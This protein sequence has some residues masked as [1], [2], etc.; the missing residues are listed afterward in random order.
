MTQ[1]IFR[2][3][4]PKSMILNEIRNVVNSGNDPGEFPKTFSRYHPDHDMCQHMHLISALNSN[5]FSVYFRIM[6]V[7]VTV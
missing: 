4:F 2:K 3:L 6:P 1:G 7:Q 5:S